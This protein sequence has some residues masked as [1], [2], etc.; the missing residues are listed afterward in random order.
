MAFFVG[1]P[2]TVNISVIGHG[3][4]P[5]AAKR[6]DKE[7]IMRERLD[8]VATH[9]VDF[10]VG[11]VMPAGSNGF[12]QG[13][14]GWTSKLDGIME[15]INKDGVIAVVRQLPKNLCEFKAYIAVL[16]KGSDFQPILATPDFEAGIPRGLGSLGAVSRDVSQF[17][18]QELQEFQEPHLIPR[19]GHPT[20]T[21]RDLI[22]L[23][24]FKNEF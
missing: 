14:A 1:V 5:I 21:Q 2:D 3:V 19:L 20:G 10:G 7:V 9:M 4:K 22:S 11:L 23:L 24:F 16:G 13:F 12:L 6:F 17:G 18:L 8:T 15:A